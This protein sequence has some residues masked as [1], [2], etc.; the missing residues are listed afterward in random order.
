MVSSIIMVSSIW[1]PDS[2][3]VIYLAPLVHTDL[4]KGNVQLIKRN[5]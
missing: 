3:K 5:V 1:C 2:F 4:I